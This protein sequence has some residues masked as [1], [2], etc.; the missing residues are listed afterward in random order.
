MW[1]ATAGPKERAGLR[2]PP[3]QKTPGGLDVRGAFLGDE[4]GGAIY[5][6]N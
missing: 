2:E 5:E 4:E 1:T 6:E 3:V